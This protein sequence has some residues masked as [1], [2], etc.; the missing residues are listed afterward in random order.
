MVVDEILER[1]RAFVRGRAPEPIPETVAATL[2]VVACYDPRLDAL[3]RGALGLDAGSAFL[4]RAAG[5]HV[6]A[7]GDPLRSLALATYLFGIE[8]ILV[9]G[10]TSCRMAQFRAGEFAD[11]F[12]ARGVPR[13]AFGDSDLRAWAGAIADPRRGV[14][15]SVAALRA[16]TILPKGLAVTG[17]VLDDTSGVLEVVVRPDDPLPGITFGGSAAPAPAEDA[18]PLEEQP[19][20][21]AAAP[22]AAPRPAQGAVDS[23]LAL[24]GKLQSKAGLRDAAM[25]LR[26]EL[27][28]TKNPIE[29][30]RLVEGFLRRAGGDAQEIRAAIEDLRRRA[31]GTPPSVIAEE[32]ARRVTELA[33]EE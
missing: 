33:R 31:T 19:R 18:A 4:L 13:E 9:V 2:A 23:A 15:A 14:V 5:A 28:A 8:E 11:A 24:V 1:N 16:A 12:R 26:L 10:H 29:K 20:A 30:L 22:G 17:A 25:R 32:V 27:G 3:L 6:S 21:P 7:A